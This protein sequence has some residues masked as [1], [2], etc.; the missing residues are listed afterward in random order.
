[1]QNLSL[2]IES[3]DPVLMKDKAYDKVAIIYN[4]LMSPVNYN[5]W[6]DYILDIAAEQIDTHSKVLELA[7]GT[8]QMAELFSKQYKNIIATDISLAMLKSN[9][10][11]NL[12]KICCDMSMLPFNTSFDFI[13]CTFDSI[14]YLLNQKQ[15]RKLFAE[16]YSLLSLDGIFT[17]DVSLELNSLKF[18]EGSIS[19]REYAGY[20]YERVSRY[21][22]RRRIHYNYFYIRSASGKKIRE[23]HKQKIYDINVYYKLA[24]K[25]G[26]RI[27]EVYDCFTFDD[28]TS[29][30]ER[31][32]FILRKIN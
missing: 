16:V 21:N 13:F 30:S 31:A 9:H 27:S 24:E 6:T 17:F 10:N 14:N 1:M 5:L 26:F 20:N 19:K 4:D 11:N 32:Q 2:K 29:K 25:T 22:N 8:C 18:I 15:L 28:V 7:S 23:V 12:N 3:V